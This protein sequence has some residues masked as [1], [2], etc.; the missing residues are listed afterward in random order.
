MRAHKAVGMSFLK[1]FSSIL[2]L[3]LEAELD[4]RILQE[5]AHRIFLQKPQD[6]AC[7]LQKGDDIFELT[8][9]DVSETGI[10][11]QSAG[12]PVVQPGEIYPVTFSH[13]GDTFQT[14]IEI[15]RLGP[16]VIGTRIAADTEVWRTFLLKTFDIELEG[17]SLHLVDS[18]LLAK[19]DDGEAWWFFSPEGRELYFVSD[20]DKI[21][22]FHFVFR[23]HHFSHD[24][25]EFRYG[26]VGDDRKEKI[27]VKASHQIQ[28]EMGPPIAKARRFLSNIERLP[29][30]FRDQIVN[31]MK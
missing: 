5:R 3:N 1:K 9:K 14:Q 4:Q 19:V 15:V 18:T 16:S 11:F 28:G 10:G 23:G 22:R 13:E 27:S 17:G 25:T 26:K 6:L 29:R 31:V 2:G 7:R 20:D 24:G 30:H 21:L 8:A 12:F